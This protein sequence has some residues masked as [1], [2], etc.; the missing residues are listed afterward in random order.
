MTVRHDPATSGPEAPAPSW[1]AGWRGPLLAAL[2]AALAGLPGLISMPPLD[3]DESRFVQ[4][5]A[6]MLE[7]NEFVVIRFQDQPRFKKPIGIHWLQAASVSLVSSPE[8]RDI[9]AYRLPSLIGAMM[10]AAACAWG[11]SVFFGTQT[12]LMAGAILG[13]SFLLSTEGF[14][15]KTDA[16]L[17]GTITLA[18]A[19]LARIYAASRGGPAA[20]PWVRFGFWA[21]VSVSTLVKGPIGPMV[22]LLTALSLWVWDRKAGWLK[23]LSWT[24][25]LILFVA[26][27]GPWAWAVT[28]ATDGAFWK[29]AIVGD[30]APKLAGGQ[31]SHGAW[32]GYHSLVALVQM[33]PSTLLLP[34]GLALGWSRRHE[35]GVRFALCWLIPTWLV[36]EI[37]PTKLSHYA[38]PAYGALAWL[39]AAALDQPIGKL[40]RRIG[41]AL[42]ALVGLLLA[43][44]T[45]YLMKLY[46]NAGDLAAALL[47]ATLFVAAGL[48][49]GY[50]F[51][52]GN[53][54]L[55]LVLALPLGLLGHGALVGLFAPGL[56][57]LLISKRTEAVLA[58][59]SLLPSQ[60]IVPGPIAVA[61]YAEPSLVFGL[62]TTTD[63]G[64]AADAAHAL[65]DHR[66]AVVEDREQPA[67]QAAVKSLKLK[68]HP[69]GVVQG[70]NYSNGDETRLTLYA[71]APEALP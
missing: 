54:T 40:S 61:G 48:Y 6:Q 45:L 27:V 14:I 5:T 15:A 31:E 22:V 67:F 20:G 55:A 51:L 63:L 62:G 68:L 47:T 65:A 52:R 3:R 66:A 10:A 35:P 17:C 49:G 23:S 29:A 26:V 59:A 9:W 39:M 71:P 16:V 13:A 43:A 25:G 4:A 18:M 28:V 11:A 41:A 50:V 44:G 70:L 8:A 36:F 21:G 24:W 32:P 46:G 7:Q 33:F 2:L 58:Q 64:D 69:I 34:A 1:M 12:G 38:L 30:L 37:T 56:D 53:S 19:C 60:G 42:Q 57:P